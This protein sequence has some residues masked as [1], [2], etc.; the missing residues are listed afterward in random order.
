MA[1]WR[2]TDGAS[3]ADAGAAIVS[4][5]VAEFEPSVTDVG[6][7]LQVGTGAGPVTVHVS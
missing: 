7:R 6:L 4:V 1:K 5:E 2:P 3:I